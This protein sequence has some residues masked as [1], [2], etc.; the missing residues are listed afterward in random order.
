MTIKTADFH[1]DPFYEVGSSTAKGSACHRDSGRAGC[2][3]A[4]RSS[5]DSP[6]SLINA[7]FTWI[8]KNIKDRIDFIIWTGDSA[9]HDN[10]EHI[11]RTKDQVIGQNKFLVQKFFE[12]F[13]KPDKID[14]PDPNNDFTIPIIPTIGNND[15]LPHNVFLPGPNKWTTTFYDIWRQFIPEFQRH[16]F[17]HGGWYY[18][19][20]IPNKL[21]VFSL[22]TMCVTSICTFTSFVEN[23]NNNNKL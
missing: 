7:T 6:I 20:V 16:Q 10:D 14:D 22:N 4:E 23:H 1:P 5:C 13:G 3:G 2:F 17:E 9:R 18:V 12:V 21:A 15:I 8:E 19:E 11:I